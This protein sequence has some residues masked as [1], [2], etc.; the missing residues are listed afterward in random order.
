MDH[1]FAHG[2]PTQNDN[3]PV[4]MAA[5]GRDSFGRLVL[6]ATDGRQ[7]VDVRPVRAFPITDPGFGLALCDKQGHELL[8]VERPSDLPAE[9]RRPV[10]EELDQREFMPVVRRIHR[11]TLGEPGQW[12]V[13]TDRGPTTFLLLSGDDIRRLDDHRAILRDVHGTRY[14]IEDLRRLDGK[15]RR[16]LERYL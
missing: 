7:W 8:W 13:E 10:E 16:I 11:V 9:A 15:S 1:R 2:Q 5:L 14:L 3:Q 6:T 4:E 12:H